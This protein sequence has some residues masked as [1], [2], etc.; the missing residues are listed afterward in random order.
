MTPAPDAARRWK[1]AGLAAAVL[2]HVLALAY[3][4]A[5]AAEH[6]AYLRRPA[7]INDDLMQHL[8][9]FY[10]NL[11]P[12]HFADRL[13]VDYSRRYLP[14][15]YYHLMDALSRALDP[16]L[17][18][19]LLGA[20]LLLASWILA[21]AIG[22]RLAGPAG[23]AVVLIL[24]VRCAFIDRNVYP[25]LF[26]SFGFPL[27]LLHVLT[28]IRARWHAAGVVLVLEA[29]FYPPA[30]LLGGAATGLAVLPDLGRL[31][32][33]RRSCL[34]AL[35]AAGAVAAATL[36]AFSAQSRAY[37][38]PIDLER[39]SYMPQWRQ[40][41]G[42]MKELPHPAYTKAIGDAFVRGLRTKGEEGPAEA[43]QT[44]RNQR[45]LLVALLAAAGVVLAR[46]APRRA[47][48][49]AAL[50]LA[51]TTLYVAARLT[52][53]KLG[54][55]SRFLDYTLPLV[56][57]LAWPAA[58][59][60]LPRTA[61]LRWR[62]ALAALLAG[63]FLFF[64]IGIPDIRSKVKD[65]SVYDPVLRFFADL[66]ERVLVTGWPG[67]ELDFLPLFAQKE[68]LYDWEHAHP[69]YL[70]YYARVQERILD[71]IALSFA[72]SRADVVRLRDRYGLTHLLVDT[73]L[74]AQTGDSPSVYQPYTDI[75]VIARRCCPPSAFV[76]HDPPESWIVFRRGDDLVI[77]L[78]RVEADGAEP[79]AAAAPAPALATFVDD[80]ELLDL[81][82]A[83]S[84]PAPAP[85]DELTVRLTWRCGPAT[86]TRDWL[87]FVHFR[88]ADGS[89]FTA[90]HGLMQLVPEAAIAYPVARKVHAYDITTAIPADAPPGAYALW[91]GLAWRATGARVAPVT[92]LPVRSRAVRLPGQ[93][94]VPARAK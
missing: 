74:P 70:D 60:A 63:A 3:A 72:T 53:F 4:C 41:I 26:R 17:A 69:I 35:A 66:P 51:G 12:D 45:A 19:K 62:F 64:P 39:A 54:F 9:P 65:A 79:P 22:W 27:L 20:T 6:A 59:G 49:L 52:A 14:P 13:L 29:L 88:H 28:W 34:Y 43:F 15:G 80:I 86:Q 90:D 82:V 56:A 84:A 67:R 50:F 38:P 37:G 91:V 85:G 2:L 23:A 89:R 87:V 71:S 42:R 1:R 10:A 77:D 36:A 46:H 81:A 93:L 44:S 76:F 83:R 57:I 24:V 94:L 30:A 8:T 40:G 33:E 7:W 61:A 47:V 68:P 78:R 58:W 92:D 75:G 5:S 32:R 48:P 16:I 25:G 55:P 18:A 73:D 21:Y 11:H 31:W